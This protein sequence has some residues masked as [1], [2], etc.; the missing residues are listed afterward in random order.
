MEIGVKPKLLEKESLIFQVS[1]HPRKL[2]RLKDS[3]QTFSTSANFVTMTWWC[4]CPK[5]NATY[6]TVV[7]NGLWGE[8]EL[9]TIVM[10]FLVSLQILRS[11]AI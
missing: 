3:R 7:A 2:C 9:L 4:N 8:K 6:L 5:R 11:S 10:V 1:G